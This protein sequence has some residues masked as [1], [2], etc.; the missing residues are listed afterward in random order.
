MTNPRPED[1]QLGRYYQSDAYISHS[2]KTLTITDRVYKIARA[3][4]LNWKYK[5]IHR[6]AAT[7]PRSVLDFGC[8]TGSF[9]RTCKDHGMHIGGVEPSDSARQLAA[10]TTGA[11]IAA[12][13]DNISDQYDVITLWH[14]LEHVSNFNDTIQQLRNKLAENGTIFIAVP[15]LNSLDAKTYKQH[16]AGYDVPRH[17]WHFS[18]KTMERI[19]SQNHLRVTTILPMKLDSFY[20]SILSEKYRNPTRGGSLVN[21]VVQGRN[22]N[23]AAK[24]TG[25]YSSLIYIARK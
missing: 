8:G 15:N 18:I 13:L 14:V 21:A 20:V 5:L 17:L 11:H 10:K 16:W 6:H 24:R 23:R 9:L 25:E 7:P 22:S 1:D 12:D 2:N 19:L 3:F 4:T